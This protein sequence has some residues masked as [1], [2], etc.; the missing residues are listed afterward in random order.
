MASQEQ[1]LPTRSST[2]PPKPSERKRAQ[3]APAPA[4]LQPPKKKAKKKAKVAK[5]RQ[6]TIPEPSPSPLPSPPSPATPAE[7]SVDEDDESEGEN[8]EEPV[9]VEDEDVGSPPPP[10]PPP[11]PPAR[12]ISVWKAVAGDV[13]ES[14][15]GKKSAVFDTQN[16]YY[17]ELDEWQNQIVLLLLPRK[18]KITRLQAVASYEKAR[19]ADCCPQDIW[20]SEDL[21][22]A[23]AIIEEWHKRWPSKSLSLNFTLYLVEEKEPET[24]APTV[25]LSQHRPAGRRTATQAQLTNLPDV[26]AAEEASGNRIPAIAYRWPCMNIHCRN[27]GKTCWQNKKSPNSPDSAINHYPISAENFQRWNKELLSGESTIEQPSQNLIINLVKERS[28]RI[29]KEQVVEKEVPTQSN[30]DRLVSVMMARELRTM[31]QIPHLSPQYV[32]LQYPPPYSNVEAPQNSSLVQSEP[33]PVELLSRF[34]EWLANQPEFNSKRQRAILKPIK[35][36]LVEEE[37][38]I[39]SLKSLK[40]GEGMTSDQWENYDFKIGTLHRIRPLISKFKRLR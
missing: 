19:Q 29:Q 7:P 6:K 28:R 1:Q 38:D 34:F 10:P 27:K 36:K 9:E 12:F 5:K 33:D 4:V 40:P 23:L 26:L 2:R 13:R 22:Q 20:S 24:Q 39:D 14:L 18:F 11:P 37:W 16:I 8:I 32:P 30:I 35:A 21:D 15:P 31:N 25:T 3:S 17:F